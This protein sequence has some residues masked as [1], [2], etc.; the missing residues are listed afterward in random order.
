MAPCP[1]LVKVSRGTQV[2][3][4][5]CAGGCRG[6]TRQKARQG[7]QVASPTPGAVALDTAPPRAVSGPFPV[8]CPNMHSRSLEKDRQ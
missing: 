2:D 3:R 1:S 4:L 8:V 6:R 7:V 5:L